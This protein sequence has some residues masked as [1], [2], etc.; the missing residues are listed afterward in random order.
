MSETTDP[1]CER[2][3]ILEVYSQRDAEMRDTYAPWRADELFM[4]TGRRRIAVRLL[5]EAGLFPKAGD[6]CLEVGFGSLGWLAELI[7]W[8]VRETDL[9]GIDLDP[10]RVRR[11]T[12]ALPA[13]DLR[14]G[15]AGNM[16]WPDEAFRLAIASTVFTSILDESMR[17]RVA[18][19]IVRVLA[20]GG[21]LLWYDFAV[22]NPRNPNVRRVTRRDL[23]VLFPHLA[24]TIS[25]VTLAPPLAR[26]LAPRSWIAATVL[27]AL[28]P[29]RTHLLGVLVKKSS[30]K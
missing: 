4:R 13:A 26:W 11:G 15:D 14:L 10:R 28:P 12:D 8:G 20:P 27:E 6:P 3:R 19:E 18:R 30:A 5:T 25:R 1:T 24:G 2:D 16:P 7:S 22:N 9:H 29:L 17:S 21:A 23:N